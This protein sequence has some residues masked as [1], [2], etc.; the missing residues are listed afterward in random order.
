MFRL[1]HWQKLSFYKAFEAGLLVAVMCLAYSSS[2]YK[3]KLITCLQS[4]M[5]SVMRH[6]HEL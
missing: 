1:I 3:D 2:A 4:S 5:L 6:Q